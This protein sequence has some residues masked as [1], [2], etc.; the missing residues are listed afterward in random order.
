MDGISIF[1]GEVAIS[2]KA[3]P[4]FAVG[5]LVMNYTYILWSSKLC[6]YYIGSTNNL[7]NRIKEHNSGKSAFTKKGV[8][9]KIIKVEEYKTKKEAYKRE[10]E[11]KSYKGGIKFKKLMGEVA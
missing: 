5:G 9:W 4:R 3:G 10:M 8:P 6:K 1:Q 11:I 2:R 7:N